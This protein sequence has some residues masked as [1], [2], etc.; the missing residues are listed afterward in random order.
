MGLC[1]RPVIRRQSR[2]FTP[3]HNSITRLRII[4]YSLEDFTAGTSAFAVH[5]NGSCTLLEMV[6]WSRH[7]RRRWNRL[8]IFTYD[9]FNWVSLLGSFQAPPELKFLSDL[10]WGEFVA[11]M[12]KYKFRNKKKEVGT[13]GRCDW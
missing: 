8:E 4:L 10:S 11:S 1:T 9:D 5:G 7:P 2:S 3:L 6:H 12:G 13:S